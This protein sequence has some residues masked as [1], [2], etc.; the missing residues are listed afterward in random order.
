MKDKTYIISPVTL[1][2]S[3]DVFRTAIGGCW[4]TVAVV[5]TVPDGAT[6]SIFPIEPFGLTG[7]D[8]PATRKC[9]KEVLVNS[10]SSRRSDDV[11]TPNYQLYV[12]VVGREEVIKDDKHWK[13]LLVGGQFGST[14]YHPI[15]TASIFDNTSFGYWIPYNK[16]EINT[17]NMINAEI[18]WTPLRATPIKVEAVYNTFLPEYESYVNQLDSELLIPNIYWMRSFDIFTPDRWEVGDDIMEFQKLYSTPTMPWHGITRFAADHSLPASMPVLSDAGYAIRANYSSSIRNF[19]SREGNVGYE[20]LALPEDFNSDGAYENDNYHVYL[21]SSIIQ[22]SLSAST[23]ETIKRVHKNIFFDDQSMR[24]DFSILDEITSTLYDVYQDPLAANKDFEYFVNYK[25]RFPYYISIDIP[26]ITPETVDVS[27]DEPVKFREFLNNGGYVPKFLKLLKDA[28]ND[29]NLPISSEELPYLTYSDYF[30]PDASKAQIYNYTTA[31]ANSFRSVDFMKLITYGH[32]HFKYEAPEIECCFMGPHTIQRLSALD[33]T[34]V[35]RYINS[36]SSMSIIKD[37]LTWFKENSTATPPHPLDSVLSTIRS[38]ITNLESFY[39]PQRDV[40]NERHTETLAYRIEKIGG[41]PTNDDKTQ[42]VLQNIWFSNGTYHS[43]RDTEY[44]HEAEPGDPVSPIGSATDPVIHYC[45]T[46]IKY[47][48]T[49]T[50]NIYAY[51]LTVGW[52]YKFSD[53]SVSRQLASPLMI[54]HEYLGGIAPNYCL[55]YYDPATDEPVAALPLPQFYPA[56]ESGF[57]SFP[58]GDDVEMSYTGYTPSARAGWAAELGSTSATDAQQYSSDRYRAEFI[59]EYEPVIKIVEVPLYTKTLKVMDNPPNR[60]EI[61]PFH[62]NDNSQRL[63]FELRYSAD[64]TDTYPAVVATKDVEI[65]SDYMNSRNF[66]T[67]QKITREYGSRSKQKYIEIYRLDRKPK[68]IT[69]FGEHRRDTLNLSLPPEEKIGKSKTIYNFYDKVKTNL[70]Y[71]YVFRVINEKGIPGDL[72]EIYEAQLIDDGG[73]KFSIFNI[74]AEEEME[75]KPF[76]IS[77]NIKKIF[78]VL[79][80]INHIAFNTGSIDY[81]QPAHTQIGK[82]TVGA[83]D[84]DEY[85]WGNT[86]KFR[87]TSKKTGR[88]IDLNI[89]YN[90]NSE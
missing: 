21:T 48:T 7:D 76:A 63:G 88:K 49:Y 79:P 1:S 72:S 67:G 59:L 29:N 12:R 82:L 2:G 26:T 20:M 31:S 14:T 68:R 6:Q 25:T 5:P 70:K 54:D 85:I 39:S 38:K 16:Y 27:H 32:N 40:D 9:I 62:I 84:I 35:F 77:S 86:Y 17:A 3:T 23:I 41:L 11:I 90:L 57:Y 22:N 50:Y 18:G 42:N 34:G 69:D 36:V 4:E 28:Y 75:E 74:I 89:K 64:H 13:T 87:L 43:V 30:G 60:L 56:G 81:T 10:A 24:G 46:Q 51:V 53:L 61:N 15:Y 73:Y 45:D 83:P 80:N 58:P 55:E 52:K 78:E 8:R 66:A 44:S 33:T 19:M 71:Y 37:V 47:D 65:K